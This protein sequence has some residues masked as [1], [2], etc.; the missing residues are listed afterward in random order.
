[1][2]SHQRRKDRRRWCYVVDLPNDGL[3]HWD[4][5]V[6]EYQERFDWCRTQFGDIV[7]RCGWRDRDMGRLWQFDSSEK[8]MLFALRW[9]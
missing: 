2:N 4:V 8:A 9:S 3:Q 6:A 1:M 7:T 5:R